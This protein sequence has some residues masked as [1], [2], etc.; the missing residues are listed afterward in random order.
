[1][2]E[3]TLRVAGMGSGAEDLLR[4]VALVAMPAVVTLSAACAR[5]PVQRGIR[6]RAAQLSIGLSLREASIGDCTIRASVCESGPTA[7]EIIATGTAAAMDMDTDILTIR[8]IRTWAAE[9]IPTGGLL[10]RLPTSKTRL[11]WQ[12]R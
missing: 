7:M 1:M 9:S 8:T 3:A 12:T 2:V 11:A 6:S 5:A 10:I 4:M